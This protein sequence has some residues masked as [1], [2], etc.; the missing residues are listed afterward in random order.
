[1]SDQD[2]VST[3]PVMVPHHA[4]PLS[5]RDWLQRAGGGFGALALLDLITSEATAEAEAKARAGSPTTP[6]LKDSSLVWKRPATAK[7]VI[8]LF[9]EGGP[10]H[11]DLFDPKPAL[12]QLAGKP[13]PP[14][15][16]PVI[17]PMGEFHSPVLASKRTWKRHG[18]CGPWVSDW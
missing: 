17:T 8:F 5:R 6:G 4:I 11:I 7:S 1:M 15:F 3:Q 9:M 18:K 16:K 13:L 14:S 10:S 2:F 12:D